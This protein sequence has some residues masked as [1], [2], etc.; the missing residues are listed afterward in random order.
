MCVCAHVYVT[1]RSVLPL[2]MCVLMCVCAHV[3]VTTR[4]VLPLRMCVLM[5]CVCGENVWAHVCVA[6]VCAHVYVTT[7]SVLPLHMCVLMWCV[8]VCVCVC[9]CVC[10]NTLS[11]AFVLPVKGLHKK[12]LVVPHNNRSCQ[13]CSTTHKDTH[14]YVP[15]HTHTRAHTYT[16]S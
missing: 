10:D 13:S 6:Y 12:H 9:S 11:P 15:S 3:Y 16:H 5:W 7:H 8:S 2:R 1:I 4:S 14:T